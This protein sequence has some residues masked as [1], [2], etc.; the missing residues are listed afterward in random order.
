M[1]TTLSV[2][3]EKVKTLLN[4]STPM[5]GQT[6]ATRVWQP[7]IDLKTLSTRVIYVVPV[8]SIE[9]YEADARDRYKK[10][11]FV[12]ILCVEKVA[13]LADATI[14]TMEIFVEAVANVFKYGTP[15]NSSFVT[16]TVFTTL[17]SQ[18]DMEEFSQL[19]G[20]IRLKITEIA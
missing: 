15:I 4:A 14:D 9:G 5:V 17:V 18:E 20:L 12:D 7:V 10:D 3:A 11:F 8:P 6:A 19:R 1:G 16:E 13:T 2:I